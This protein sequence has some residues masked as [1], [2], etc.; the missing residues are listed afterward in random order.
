MYQATEDISSRFNSGKKPRIYCTKGETLFPLTNG[1]LLI[2]ASKKDVF[3]VRKE[4]LRKID[5]TPS[6]LIVTIKDVADNPHINANTFPYDFVI[7]ITENKPW[8]KDF[9]EMLKK[10]DIEETIKQNLIQ[11]YETI[12]LR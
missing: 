12:D 9:I 6:K 3:S 11:R 5:M 7:G 8:E 4:K 2:V 1:D 10:S